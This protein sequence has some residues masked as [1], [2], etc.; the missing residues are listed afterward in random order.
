[1]GSKRILRYQFQDA[2]Q[3]LWGAAVANGLCLLGFLYAQQTSVIPTLH[4]LVVVASALSI[5]V[6]QRIPMSHT[7]RL[8]FVLLML[9]HWGIGLAEIAT[10]VAEIDHGV[11]TDG[12][13]MTKGSPFAFIFRSPPYVYALIRLASLFCFLPLARYLGCQHWEDL[14]QG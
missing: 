3:Q 9:A 14:D 6:F 11:R 7:G 12:A 1:M 13:Y 2:R 5:I 4:V 10:W 8:N